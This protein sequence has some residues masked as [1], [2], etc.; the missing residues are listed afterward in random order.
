ML[1]T[2][3]LEDQEES[4]MTRPAELVD[5]DIS[6]TGYANARRYYEMKK[7]ASV[8]AQK[9]IDVAESAIKAAEKKTRAALSEVKNKSR[10]MHMR[11]P[12]WFE[13]FN[14]FITTDNYLVICGKDAQQNEVI[15]IPCGLISVVTLQTL[16]KERGHLRACRYSWS[17]HLHY[18]KSKC[19]S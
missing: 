14:W 6:E 17:S 12:L 4:E 18:K 3:K 8:K 10:I 16:S 5:I 19:G 9:T 13:K 2:N 11:K 7:K 15:G 1:L